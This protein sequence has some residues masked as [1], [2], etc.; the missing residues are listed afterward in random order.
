LLGTRTRGSEIN[1]TAGNAQMAAAY[2]YRAAA[3]PMSVPPSE[4]PR[5]IPLFQRALMLLRWSLDP[6][7]T[8]AR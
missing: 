7:A 5:S 1:T 3:S 8:I 2:P 6:L 4:A